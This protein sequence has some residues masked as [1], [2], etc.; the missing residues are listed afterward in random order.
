MLRSCSA[1]THNA[2]MTRHRVRVPTI[3]NHTISTSNPDDALNYIRFL[4]PATSVKT[5]LTYIPAQSLNPGCRFIYPHVYFL[6]CNCRLI[7]SEIPISIYVYGSNWHS[8][9]NTQN[10]YKNRIAYVQNVQS[11]HNRHCNEIYLSTCSGTEITL[12]FFSFGRK[13]FGM[14]F[15]NIC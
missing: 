1:L 14:C 13:T 7:S 4:P 8:F 3:G 10:N 9:Y 12:S 11:Q 2:G 15:A 6:S 5:P